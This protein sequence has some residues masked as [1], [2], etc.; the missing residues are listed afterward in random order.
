[1]HKLVGWWVGVC[2]SALPWHKSLEAS[3]GLVV[4]APSVCVCR[5]EVFYTDGR[6]NGAG[7]K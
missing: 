5:A 3:R 1:M 7:E 6:A 2:G 4:L